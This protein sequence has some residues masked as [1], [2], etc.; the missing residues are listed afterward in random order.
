[1]FSLYMKPKMLLF[2]NPIP[3]SQGWNQPL[4]ERH[5]TKSSRN[6]VKE[7]VVTKSFVILLPQKIIFS[8]K[9]DLKNLKHFSTVRGKI[10]LNA[11]SKIIFT[12]LYAIF[13]FQVLLQ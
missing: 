6:R 3:T 2:L 11:N 9:N 13:V 5:V 1:M 10:F 12:F 4:Y 7:G 8:L